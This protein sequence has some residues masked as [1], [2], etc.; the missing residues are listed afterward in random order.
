[1]PQHLYNRGFLDGRHSDIKIVA[2]GETYALHRLI[3]DQAAFFALAL[4]EPWLEASAKEIIL[5]PEDIDQNITK[6]SFELA[7]KRLYGCRQPD[8]EDEEAIGLFATGCWL[9]MPDL[10]E[11]SIL[12][13]LRC[14]TMDNI[15]VIIQLVTMNYYGKNGERILDA[16]RS[17]VNRDGWSMSM[18]CWETIPSDVIYDIVGGDAFY[19]PREIDRWIL[20]TSILNKK[21]R[22]VAAQND[23]KAEIAKAAMK[24]LQVAPRTEKQLSGAPAVFVTLYSN[25]EIKPLL[26]LLDSSIHYMW[27][28]F[29]QLQ[30]VRSARDV[31]GNP[32][33]PEKIVTDALWQNLQLRRNVLSARHD[34][35][36]LHL[37]RVVEDANIL[38]FTSDDAHHAD[39]F[40]DE[41]H[42]EGVQTGITAEPEEIDTNDTTKS[43]DE[44]EQPHR[45]WIPP[46]DSNSISGYS[47]TGNTLTRSTTLLT[48]PLSPGGLHDPPRCFSESEQRQPRPVSYSHIPPFRFAVELPN[49]KYMKEKKKIHSTNIWIAGSMWNVYCQKIQ[50][51]AGPRLGFY[52]YRAKVLDANESLA[53]SSV[54]GR[55][56]AL[57]RDMLPH[58]ERTERL[59]RK[60]RDQHRS[61]TTPELTLTD[62]S[63]NLFSPSYVSQRSGRGQP[64]HRRNYERCAPPQTPLRNGHMEMSDSSDDESGS[65]G[66]SSNML[67]WSSSPQIRPVAVLPPYTDPRPIIKA[68]F[69]IYLSS[70]AGRTTTM[71]ESAPDTFKRSQSWGWE[72]AAMMADEPALFADIDGDAGD[73]DENDLDPYEPWH[74]ETGD[75]VDVVRDGGDMK[76]ASERTVRRSKR[77]T[78]LKFVVVLGVV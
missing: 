34:D 7:L 18:K 35:P 47:S 38:N 55:I 59:W 5:H 61:I 56:G 45:Y 33:V 58:G 52:L 72:S 23:L 11:D 53:S 30:R 62:A 51:N 2:F 6:A 3:L 29:E 31:Y 66:Q 50:G 73:S 64:Q 32:Q 41:N 43:K 36:S 37:S 78:K 67:D 48:S 69:K 60:R 39:M 77:D 16:A 21:L 20:A 75:M 49:P 14:M 8:E 46:S 25:S 10:I 26:R 15:A 24:P 71:Y 12:A 9:E 74:A 40:V 22:R 57:E 44:V 28:D 54:E 42:T 27:L 63:T 1:L 17:L 4:K 65:V 76:N 68:Y 70:N 19:I 13:I